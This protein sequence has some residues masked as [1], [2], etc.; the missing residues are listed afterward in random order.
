M[1]IKWLFISQLQ[2]IFLNLY[3]N[4]LDFLKLKNLLTVRIG[5]RSIILRRYVRDT[6]NVV[7]KILILT[8]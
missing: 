8:K 7:R 5:I 1:T 2:K 3:P 4:E 6:G